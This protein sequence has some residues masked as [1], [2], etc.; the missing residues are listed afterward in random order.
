MLRGQNQKTGPGLRTPSQS[1]MQTLE[2]IGQI[3][4]PGIPYLKPEE[5]PTAE[6]TPQHKAQ[7]KGRLTKFDGPHLQKTKQKS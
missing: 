6:Y 5:T 1:H 2:N 3:P 4:G 7:A